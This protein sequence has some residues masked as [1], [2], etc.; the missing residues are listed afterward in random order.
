MLRSSCALSLFTLLLAG[1]AP[2]ASPVEEDLIPPDGKVF[3]GI[4]CRTILETP[5]VKEQLAE[6]K[7]SAAVWLAQ[8][9]LAGFDPFESLDE[10]LLVSNGAAQNPTMFAI[11][12]GRFHLVRAI[13][14]AVDYHGVPVLEKT[15]ADS[16]V[17]ALDDET[18]IFGPLKMVRAAI[19]RRGHGSNHDAERTA[20]L[21]RMRARYATWAY[22]DHL[23]GVEV[24]AGGS[25][26]LSSLDRFEFGA[27]VEHGM[28]ITGSM[29][30]CS[31][32][33][34]AKLATWAAI[35]QMAVRSQPATA[36]AKFET[37]VEKNTLTV[38]ASISAESLRKAIE[39][40]KAAMAKGVAAAKAAGNGARNAPRKA[41]TASRRLCATLNAASVL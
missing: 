38:T 40:Q 34:A 14:N 24:P 32:A 10:V 9:P 23:D 5:L 37:H 26:K 15:G 36:G 17:A 31:D 21:E 4:Q 18:A 3:V 7:K 13:P 33:D 25:D 1:G 11:L 6:A 16:A 12:K 35:I 8:N 30:V 41:A 2:A 28:E 29:H 39:Q 20:R 27:T 19:D 22:G